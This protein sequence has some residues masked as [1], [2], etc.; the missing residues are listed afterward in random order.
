LRSG[1]SA[2]AAAL[3]AERLAQKPESRL[4]L[5]LRGRS[6]QGVRLSAKGGAVDA[7]A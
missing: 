5:R 3:A 1:H 6:E 2:L 7:I 4:N